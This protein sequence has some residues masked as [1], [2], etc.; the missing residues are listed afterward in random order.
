MKS[1]IGPKNL[2][3]KKQVEKA[4]KKKSVSTLKAELQKIFNTYIR[5]RDTKYE[6]GKAF[7]VCISCNYPKEMDQMHA[8]HF[9][10]VGGNEAVRFDEDN[11]HGQCLKCN[12]FLHGNLLPYQAALIKKIG[13]E[14]FEL[15]GIKRMNRSKMMAFEI[16]V[17]KDEYENKIKALKSGSALQFD[18]SIPSALQ[19]SLKVI[20]CL[21]LFS[22]M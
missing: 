21:N 8:G 10:P 15:L 11:V 22:L 7:F 3:Y 16:E 4:L 12:T 9:Y 6:N 5:L 1:Y 19:N 20:S 2:N 18:A 17:L 14:R 13:K